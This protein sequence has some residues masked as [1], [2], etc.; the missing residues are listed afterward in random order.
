M[1][2]SL[3]RHDV[4]CVLL[5]SSKHAVLVSQS[6]TAKQAEFLIIINRVSQCPAN[7]SSSKQ[8]FPHNELLILPLLLQATS[9][10]ALGFVV[11][12][13]P[14]Q[15]HNQASRVDACNETE[16]QGRTVPTLA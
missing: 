11:T 2:L 9:Q 10:C 16:C 4:H 14:I 15:K 12:S 1:V 6:V 3:S 7:G 8:T 13:V 5:A